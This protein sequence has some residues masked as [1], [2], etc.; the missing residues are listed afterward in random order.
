MIIKQPITNTYNTH[1]YVRYNSAHVYSICAS[2]TELCLCGIIHTNLYTLQHTR[3]AQYTPLLC[4]NVY[5]YINT[6]MLDDVT[7]R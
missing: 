5:L 6:R 2:F 1:V 7:I 3:L 4:K